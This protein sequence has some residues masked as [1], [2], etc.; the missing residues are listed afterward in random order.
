MTREPW[1]RG[2]ELGPDELR[3]LGEVTLAVLR[4]LDA[5]REAHGADE[6]DAELV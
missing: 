5:A 6:E 2:A 4:R 1:V 3:A